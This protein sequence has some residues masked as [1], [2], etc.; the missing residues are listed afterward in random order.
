MSVPQ[1]NKNI[2]TIWSSNSTPGY[3]SRESERTISERYMHPYIQCKS[4][5]NT[6]GME[7]T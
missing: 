3:L 4:V 1:K 6:Q 7:A 2:T 5:C